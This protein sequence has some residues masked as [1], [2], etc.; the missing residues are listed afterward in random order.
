M[1]G[2]A[3]S[4]KNSLSLPKRGEGQGEGFAIEIKAPH[5]GPLL[6]WRGEGENIPPP[7]SLSVKGIVPILNFKLQK[8]AKVQ[9][10]KWL[11]ALLF[12]IC[13]LSGHTQQN[14]KGHANNFTS[15]EYYE[16]PNERQM[17]TRLSGTQA[18][19]LPGGLLAIKN[20]K[21]ETFTLSGQPEIT[22]SVPEC[23][24]DTINETASSPGHLQL[25]YGAGKFQVEGDGFLWRQ[26]NSFL[27]ISNNIS[28]VIKMSPEN[29]T[30]P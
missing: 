16:A 28:S 29:T 1:N 3:S 11:L 22:A 8:K 25:D 18:Q 13:E 4:P 23:V 15:T 19:P 27:T 5:P 17:K 24:Y 14:V 2:I 10:A 21:L 20:F 9:S 7:T 12:I 6:V 30:A 26:T